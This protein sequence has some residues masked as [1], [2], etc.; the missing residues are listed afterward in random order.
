MSGIGK[1][2]WPDGKIYEGNWE[3]NKTRGRGVL[4]T[5]DGKRH[6]GIFNQK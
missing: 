3:N 1:Y 4:I 5:T 2:T 6:E